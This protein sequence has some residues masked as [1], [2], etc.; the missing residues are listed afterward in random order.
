MTTR[1]KPSSPEAD[2]IYI[3]WQTTSAGDTFPLYN[4]TAEDHPLNGSTVTDKT[5]NE[6]NLRIPGAPIPQNPGKKP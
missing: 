6:L 5:L 2:A 4:I 1:K 3:G